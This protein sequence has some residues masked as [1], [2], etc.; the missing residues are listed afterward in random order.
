MGAGDVV[1]F[2]MFV[3]FVVGMFLLL[4]CFGIVL[5]LFSGSSLLSGISL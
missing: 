3:G 2:R 1:V 4:C 5:S